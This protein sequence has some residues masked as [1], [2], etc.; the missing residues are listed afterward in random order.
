MVMANMIDNI[1]TQYDKVNGKFGGIL[2]AVTSYFG[3]GLI[4]V[5]MQLTRRPTMLDI[6]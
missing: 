3:L 2:I 1:K 6:K 5:I 4:M